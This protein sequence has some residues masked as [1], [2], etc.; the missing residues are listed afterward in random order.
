MEVLP[1]IEAMYVHY[2]VERHDGDFF[3]CETCNDKEREKA[4]GPSD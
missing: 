3:E 1:A 2:L 4:N